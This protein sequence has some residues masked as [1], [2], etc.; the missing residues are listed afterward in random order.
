MP[1]TTSRRVFENAAAGSKVGDAVA[2]EDLDE[3]DA[4]EVLTYNMFS[5]TDAAHFL[6]QQ[7]DGPDH[8]GSWRELDYENPMRR[9]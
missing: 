1:A 4:Q 2:A 3:F 7:S 6:N 5:G 8:G 9:G